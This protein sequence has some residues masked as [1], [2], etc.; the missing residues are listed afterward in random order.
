MP[1]V[2]DAGVRDLTRFLREAA[3]L[4]LTKEKG[5]LIEFRLRSIAEEAGM[6]SLSQLCRQLGSPGERGLRDKV[7]EAMTTHETLFFRDAVVFDRVRQLIDAHLK[8]HQRLPRVWSAACSTGQEPY[9]VG[10]QFL[11]LGQN[12]ADRAI[13]ATD[14]AEETLAA[15]ALGRYNVLQVNR[16]LPIALMIKYFERDGAGWKVKPGLRRL[17]DFRRANLIDPAPAEGPFDIVLCRNVLIYFDRPTAAVILERLRSVLR[18]GGTLV[19]GASENLL[20]REK[21]F[22]PV[23]GATAIYRAV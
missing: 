11:E 2:D 8:E 20:G 17:V 4:E 7:I 12:P 18:V 15:A 19:L 14:I 13:I 9:S 10:I 5:Y 22:L 23:A 6:V 3:G 16:G 21:G 1:F